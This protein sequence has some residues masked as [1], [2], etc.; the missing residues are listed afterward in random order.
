MTAKAFGGAAQNYSGPVGVIDVH[1]DGHQSLFV[2][3][4]G[5]AFACCSTRT[6]P[7]FRWWNRSQ[8]SRCEY[9][10]ALRDMNNDHYEDVVMRGRTGIA[11]FQIRDERGHHRHVAA[12]PGAG[13]CRKW[14][15]GGPGFQFEAR[16]ADRSR[17]NKHVRVLRNLGNPY[18]TDGT[19]NSAC[20]D[21]LARATC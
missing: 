4:A 10:R 17:G 18:F 11:R 15:S 20:R 14:N 5:A 6:E 1:R 8:P 19:T 7:S 9:H 12:A 21:S 3:E 13:H 2:V 16:P